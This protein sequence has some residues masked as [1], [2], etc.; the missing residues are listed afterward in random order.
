MR[1][2]KAFVRALATAAIVLGGTHQALAQ[3]AAHTHVGIGVK[4]GFEGFGVDVAVPVAHRVNARIGFGTFSLSHDFD[5]DGQTL[6]AKLK[7]GDVHAHV[8]LFPFGGGFHIS[9]GL[10]LHNSTSVSGTTSVQAGD[11]FTLNDVDYR[12]SAFDPVKGTAGVSFGNVAPSVLLGW[13]NIVPRGN[14]RWGIQFETGVIFSKAPTFAMTMS[15]HGCQVIT[16]NNGQ[17]TGCGP[18]LDLATDPTVKA[19]LQAEIDK[20]NKDLKSLTIFPVIS[21]GFS[22]KF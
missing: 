14:R 16:N 8:D 20:T 21:L 3:T 13:G 10:V 22:Y 15:G 19:N 1:M 5:E 17:Q 11:T 7:L 12:G 2:I 4:G 6:A 18:A 9:P